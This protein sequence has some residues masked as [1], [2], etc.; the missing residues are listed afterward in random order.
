MEDDTFYEHGLKFDCTRCGK[1]CQQSGHLFLSALDLRRMAECLNMSDADFFQKYCEVVDLRLVK[2][3]S[4]V[5]DSS[6]AC[7]F[8]GKNG[9]ELYEHRPL[10]CRSFPF[11][12]TNLMDADCWQE[13][14]DTCRGINQGRLWSAEEIS[15]C[16]EERE[17]DP[18]LDVRDR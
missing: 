11:W 2:R 18:L 15:Q 6:G 8:L 16:L 13:A 12:S 14:A 17:H 9:C 10:Q 5:A 1:C 7:V 4:L 3:V